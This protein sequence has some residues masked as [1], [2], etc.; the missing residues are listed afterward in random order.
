[1]SG[2][3]TITAVL[4]VLLLASGCLGLFAGKPKGKS[5]A[6]LAMA[7]GPDKCS[8]CHEAWS[9]A[10]DYYRG[11]DRY[12]CI[13]NGV[14]ID[15]YYDPWLFP[16]VRNTA[17][18]YYVTPWWDT[19]ETYAWPN[20][21]AERAFSM[22][23]LTSGRKLP[24]IPSTPQAVKGPVVVVSRTG[25]GD[26][27]S[28]QKAVDRAASGTV[29]Y[30]RSGTY[31]ETVFLKEGIRLIGQDPYTTIIDPK[32]R[33]HAVTAANRCQISGFTL[34]GTNIDYTANRM[35]AGIYVPG[36]DSTLVIMGNIFKQNGL[37]GVMVESPL[38]STRNAAFNRAHP[39]DSADYADRP[40]LAA[41][42]PII[43]G[44]TFYRIGQRAIFLLHGRAEIF[45]NIFIGN[46]KTIGLERHSRPFVHHNVFYMN[47]IPMSINRS[48]PIVCNNIMYH[49]QWGQRL[50]KGS[51]PVIF[52][53]VTWNSPHFR[54]FDEA[55]NPVRYRPVPGD[56]EQEVDPL[57]VDPPRG[58]FHFKSTSPFQNQALGIAAVG[59]MR[60]PELPQPPEVACEQSY[61]REVLALTDDILELIRKVDAE[62]AKIQSVEASYRIEYTGWLAP[63]AG[64][65][66]IPVALEF[67]GETPAV[68]MV[69]ETSRWSAQGN[70]RTKTFREW[71]QSGGEEITDSGSTR[72]NGSNLEVTGSRFAG[73]F[74]ET[75]DA[76]FIGDRPFRE[77]PLGVY[78]DYD[79]YYRGSAGPMGTFFQGYLRVLGGKI[80]KDRVKVDGR[81][82]VAVRYP[83]IGKDQ[84]FYFYLDPENG[85]RP[86]KM[87]QY[88]NGKLYREMNSYRYRMFPGKISLPVS[89]RVTDYAVAGPN[90][91]KKVGEWTLTVNESSLR[92]NGKSAVGK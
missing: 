50:L 1:M 79:Q 65:E 81:S 66:G 92:V 42:N 74:R 47:N 37:F 62:Q 16:K 30:V 70:T 57:F 20:N 45:N 21:I 18:E 36:C 85:Y 72:Y 34:T 73:D 24:D 3:M 10:W 67:T 77:A 38:D 63:K 33:G 58:D 4:T 82:C 55:G 54:D 5:A 2:G 88:Y 61:G 78:R 76:R 71:V 12:G 9:R 56:G 32:N 69:Y 40:A 6:E 22:S 25:N 75:P 15:G 44:N 83:H 11:W 31:N 86:M 41:A 87:T 90:D 43:A 26:T 48:E 64:P 29:V 35:N 7:T 46:V 14:E 13:F 59:I 39:G 91:G 27:D 80:E 28:I 8:R 17:R 89:V 19:P 68:R 60:D 52:G 23:I 84:Y 49:N 51:N 53:N